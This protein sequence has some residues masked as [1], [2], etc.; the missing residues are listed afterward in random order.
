[1]RWEHVG[2][3]SA[4]GTAS[5]DRSGTVCCNCAPPQLC[6]TAT[7]CATPQA[8]KM[9]AV[10]NA[11]HKHSKLIALAA[12]GIS[13]NL[14]ECVGRRLA[15]DRRTRWQFR[16]ERAVK[17]QCMRCTTQW[18]KCVCL[19]HGTR[20]QAVK[21]QRR[22]L[23]ERLPSIL[24]AHSAQ[25]VRSV[26]QRAYVMSWCAVTGT[27]TVRWQ[28][29]CCGRSALQHHMLLWQHCGHSTE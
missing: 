24:C 17:A 13:P 7:V 23:W 6:A 25:C 16:F 22:S 20:L 11:C 12:D 4:C 28:L 26:D 21:P 9:C 27:F 19:R 15:I 29:R 3:G 1:M 10:S 5:C 2:G 18:R 8:K 14:K